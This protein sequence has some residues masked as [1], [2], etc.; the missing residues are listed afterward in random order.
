MELKENKRKEKEGE[1]GQAE[2]PQE[3]IF[4]FF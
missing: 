3:A 2:E 4:L 1:K